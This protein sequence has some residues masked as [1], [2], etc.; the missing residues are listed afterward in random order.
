MMHTS[1][2]VNI[3]MAGS[4]ALRARECAKK[5]ADWPQCTLSFCYSSILLPTQPQS[6]SS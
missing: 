4:S 5:G 6:A 3:S 2:F 1:L